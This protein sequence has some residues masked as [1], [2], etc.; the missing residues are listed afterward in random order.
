VF[1]IEQG[2][3]LLHYQLCVSLGANGFAE[4]CLLE[5]GFHPLF[6]DELFSEKIKDME[7]T[8]QTHDF[9]AELDKTI[10][11]FLLHVSQYFLLRPA[12]KCIEWLIYR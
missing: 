1:S 11:L 8:M 2:L 7:R 3:N 4:I 12:Q 9:N 5:P 6:H 10:D